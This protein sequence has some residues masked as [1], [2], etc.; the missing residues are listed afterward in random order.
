MG[1]RNTTDGRGARMRR[2]FLAGAALFAVLACVSG[3]RYGGPVQKWWDDRGP[4]IPHDSFPAD[5]T[6]CHIGESWHEIRDDF[7]FDHYARTGV[8]LDGAHASAECLRCHNDRGPVA[9]FAARGCAGCHEDVHR[10]ELGQNC[11][12]CHGEL[13]WRPTGVIAMHNSTRFPL[14]GAHAAAACWRCHPGAQVG[15]FSHAD[16]ECVTCHADDLARAQSPNHIG[17]G[18]VSSCDRCHIPTTWTGGGF[19]H[20]TFPLT[21]AHRTTDCEDCHV[22]GVFSGTPRDCSA[23]HLDDYNGALDPDHVALGIPLRCDRCHGT[24]GWTPAQFDHAWVSSPCITCHLD[25]YNA[26]TDPD[27][28]AEMFPTECQQCHST[29]HW[30]PASF[31]HGGISNG[32]IDCHADDY[33]NT[34]DPDH[35]QVGFPTAC[36]VCHNT[37][38]WHNT[39]WNHS[40]PINNGDHSNF[41][42]IDCHT[43]G[44]FPQ[45]SC[46]DCHEHRQSETDDEHDDVPG[47]VYSSPACLACHPDGDD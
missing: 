35:Q 22:G 2:G 21:G 46:I 32:C 11:K 47:Y 42:C 16:T 15:D 20:G 18:W 38:N 40:F 23:C 37:S 29:L 41:D 24:G 7:E 39:S 19:N 10:G 36:E 12:D 43:T 25:D 30:T 45:F 6:L 26:T 27:H 33:A 3:G 5:C 14:V 34:S 1:A 31:D 17:Q 8:A 9:T 4:V 28:Q 44:S 13:D